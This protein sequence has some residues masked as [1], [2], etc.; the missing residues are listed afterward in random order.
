MTKTSHAST[1]L[2]NFA[3]HILGPALVVGGISLSITLPAH[4]DSWGKSNSLSRI[5]VHA[6]C[7]NPGNRNVEKDVNG[8]FC[9][10]RL[11]YKVGFAANKLIK[12]G[13]RNVPNYAHNEITEPLMLQQLVKIFYGD[14]VETWGFC[15]TLGDGK[16]TKKEFFRSIGLPKSEEAYYVGHL[17][18]ALVGKDNCIRA[19]QNKNPKHWAMGTSL[20]ELLDG[21]IEQLQNTAG[22][23]KQ[24]QAGCN[25]DDYQAVWQWIQSQ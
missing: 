1:I 16:C 4:A 20:A 5:V 18:A 13:G 14:K 23:M 7:G 15:K 6:V 3:F 9:G 10:N 11:S 8:C 19:S 17:T 24:F 22:W 12:C 21:G 25:N 2:H